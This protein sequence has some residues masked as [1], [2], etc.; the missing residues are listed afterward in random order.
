MKTRTIVRHDDEEAHGRGGGGGALVAVQLNHLIS[1]AF[2]AC[3]RRLLKPESG[4]WACVDGEDEGGSTPPTPT[5]IYFAT[6]GH[7]RVSGV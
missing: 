7:S 3:L 6:T 2:H 4:V 1:I 5:L